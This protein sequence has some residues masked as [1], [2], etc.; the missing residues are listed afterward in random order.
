MFPLP[1]VNV[2]PDSLRLT[3]TEQAELDMIKDAARERHQ[4]TY[5]ARLK[6]GLPYPESPYECSWAYEEEF[7]KRVRR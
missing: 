5:A 2:V 1:Q 6:R 4:K 7:R 3:P